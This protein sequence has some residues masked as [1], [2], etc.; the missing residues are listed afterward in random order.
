[1]HLRMQCNFTDIVKSSS[2]TM[3]VVPA[4]VTAHVGAHVRAVLPLPV[5]DV[6]VGLTWSPVVVVELAVVSHPLPS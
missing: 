5:R 3:P 1:M 6:T 2:A 4:R